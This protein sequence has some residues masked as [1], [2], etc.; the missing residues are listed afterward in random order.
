MP[1]NAEWA[2]LTF[3]ILTLLAKDR[4]IFFSPTPLLSPL[5]FH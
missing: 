4:N 3:N 2:T 5:L 1:D